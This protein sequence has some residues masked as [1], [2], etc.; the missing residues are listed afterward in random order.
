MQYVKKKYNQNKRKQWTYDSIGSE[1]ENAK[2]N[3]EYIGDQ[4]KQTIQNTRQSTI[5]QPTTKKQE[6]KPNTAHYIG[7]AATRTATT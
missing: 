1:T 2:N 4:A 6:K 3:S 7:N 5:Q